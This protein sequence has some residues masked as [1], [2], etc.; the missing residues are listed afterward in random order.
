MSP[1]SSSTRFLHLFRRNRLAAW[2]KGGRGI[3]SITFAFDGARIAW[4]RLGAGDPIVLVHGTPFSSEVWRRIAPALARRR[5][6]YVFDLLG[7]GRSEMGPHLD[8]SLGVQNRVLSALL[9]HWD[10][11]APE[12]VAHDFGGATALRAHFLDG[13]AYRRL[14]LVDPV[15]VAPWGSPF[16]QHVRAHEAAFAGLPAYAHEAMLRAYLQ[17]AAQR[18]LSEEA[19]EAYAAP[20]RGSVGHPAFYRQIAAMD[21]RYT[22]AVEPLY[23]PPDFPVRLLWGRDDAW[24]PVERGRALAETLTGG[25]LTEIPGAGHLVQEDAPEEILA[26]VLT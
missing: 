3:H 9:A 6:V 13:V 12:V 1:S 17:S 16:V 21:Q 5:T 14:T 26:A 22:D 23:A 19:L 20:W 7:Y 10:L 8:V 18:P 25:V 15:A 4:G 11:T 24:I 2:R